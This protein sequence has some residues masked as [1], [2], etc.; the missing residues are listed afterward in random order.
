MIQQRLRV[1]TNSR[2]NTVAVP[3]RASLQAEDRSQLER[4]FR[5]VMRD[6]ERRHRVAA[7]N[8]FRAR[9]FRS[10]KR[11]PIFLRN[12][13]LLNPRLLGH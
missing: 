12:P 13:W 3:L 1:R 9:R 10:G 8:R 4:A 6:S 5:G 7:W 2:R 11:I